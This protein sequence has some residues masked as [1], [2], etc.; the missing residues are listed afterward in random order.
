MKGGWGRVG[1]ARYAISAARY[2]KHKLARV[3]H[4]GKAAPPKSRQGG[5]ND[6]QMRMILN[7]K[8]IEGANDSRLTVETR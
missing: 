8:S 3:E 7:F 6:Y 5:Q 4:R 2:A 1:A